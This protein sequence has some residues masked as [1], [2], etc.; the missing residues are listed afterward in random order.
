MLKRKDRTITDQVEFV[1][2][3]ALVPEDHLLQVVEAIK[4]GF[5]KSDTVFI[6]ATHVKAS[7][8]KNKYIKKMT[9][10]DTGLDQR[11][12]RLNVAKCPSG[13]EQAFSCRSQDIWTLVLGHC[14]LFIFPE[15]TIRV[16]VSSVFAKKI[17]FIPRAIAGSIYRF[18]VTFYS[19]CPLHFWSSPR[20]PL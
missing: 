10:G 2:I 5:I 16:F 20:F 1:S 17:C 9:N 15:Y 13:Y 3:S 11:P 18:G 7:A 6:D 12:A 19:K 8:N 4:C 14:R